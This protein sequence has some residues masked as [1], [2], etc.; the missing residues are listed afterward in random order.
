MAAAIRKATGQSR[1]RAWPFPWPLVVALQPFVRLF[2]E[3]AEMRYLWAQSISLD[4]GKLR[5]FLGSA[6]PAT[7]LDAAVRDTLAGLGC[8]DE[9]EPRQ[10]RRPEPAPRRA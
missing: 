4:G 3:V 5:G 7:P 6:L 2:Q 1:L 9:A 8:L 10:R